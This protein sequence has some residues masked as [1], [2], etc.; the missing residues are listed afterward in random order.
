MQRIL[1]DV[2]NESKDA[3]R[4][5]KVIYI[6]S[7]ANITITSMHGDQEAQ[8]N[9]RQICIRKEQGSK[10]WDYLRCYMREGKSSDCQKSVSL[11][12]GKLN[13]CTNASSRGLAY[14]KKDFDLANKFSISGSLPLS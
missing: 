7:V 4:H 2:I 11:D 8:E 12:V 1:A 5:L 3:E 14:A 9:L 6:G 10:Y 13:S